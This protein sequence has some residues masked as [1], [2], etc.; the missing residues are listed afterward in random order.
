MAI[1]P[2]GELTVGLTG[3]LRS[4]GTALKKDLEQGLCSDS[5]F[6]ILPRLAK[7]QLCLTP[8]AWMYSSC[9]KIPSNSPIFKK[10]NLLCAV[11][12]LEHGADTARTWV[13]LAP[14][15]SVD[16]TCSPHPQWPCVSRLKDTEGSSD[17]RMHF[18]FSPGLYQ[19]SWIY[20]HFLTIHSS[21][22]LICLYPLTPSPSWLK[23]LPQLSWSFSPSPSS[24]PS[25]ILPHFLY[26]TS[27]KV[28]R[29]C[30]PT[31]LLPLFLPHG[32][33][34]LGFLVLLP[35]FRCCLLHVPLCSLLSLYAD[36]L[37][38]CISTSCFSS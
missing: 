10:S 3:Y 2:F 14:L 37:K 38:L 26:L 30:W 19:S 36:T 22:P 35:R 21:I 17:L 9:Y 12:C 28:C 29:C 34:F 33:H 13:S 31:N 5:T 16:R 4:Q 7:G 24:L 27:R 1:L 6:R 23:L 15:D 8:F 32:P 18:V 11:I 25:H 20:P